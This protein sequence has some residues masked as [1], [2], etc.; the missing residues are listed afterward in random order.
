MGVDTVLY[1][2]LTVSLNLDLA[3]GVVSFPG[4]PWQVETLVSIENAVAGSGNDTL[5]GSDLGNRLEGGAGNDVLFGGNGSD[6]LFGGAGNDTLQGGGHNDRIDGG[7]GSD[8][9]SYADYR[10]THPSGVNINL[11]TQTV[12]FPG[13]GY[14]AEILTSIEN[15]IGSHDDTVTG[16]SAANVIT[17]GRGENLVDGG[18]GN[19]LITGGRITYSGIQ[20][21][22]GEIL[23]GG[24]GNDTIDGNG[25]V[26]V[27]I[28]SDRVYAVDTFYGDG[29]ND[30][31]IAGIC[32]NEMTGG[33]R[34]DQFVFSDETDAP[35]AYDNGLLAQWGTVHDFSQAQGD[36]IAI[37]VTEDGVTPTFVGAS[38]A[39]EAGEYGYT[40]SGNDTIVS[41]FIESNHVYNDKYGFGYIQSVKVDILLQGVTYDMLASD[42]LFV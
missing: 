20:E 15:F 13:T 26:G 36:K 18:G 23:R 34:A 37:D 3:Q 2:E 25:A 41:Y 29:G 31:L 22:E 12:T 9:V 24:A 4:K 10:A 6:S 33:G 32:D 16:S 40:R 30:V 35:Y 17:C 11:A 28:N 38:L 7:Q 42:F 27:S 14:A 21:T 39:D 8:T 19:D 5:T 1:S